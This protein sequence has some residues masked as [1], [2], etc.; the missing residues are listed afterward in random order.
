SQL[1][2]RNTAVVICAGLDEAA[3]HRHLLALYQPCLDTLL[4]DPL[5]QLLKQVRFLK[6]T[7]PILREGRMI[8]DLLVETESGEPTPG[9]VHAQL[10]YQPP[11][12]RN[13]IQIP[14]QQN[15]QQY[16]RINRWAAG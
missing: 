6:S 9:Q 13:A 10:F 3:V 1:F 8:R 5:E 4:H 14:Q 15:A 16:D 11:L 7:V 2:P 12:A